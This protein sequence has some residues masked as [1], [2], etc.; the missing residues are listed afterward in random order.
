MI[1]ILGGTTE[2]RA[3]VRVA[4]EANQPYFYSTKGTLQEVVC[5]HGTRLTG[6]MDV[7]AMCQF[8]AANGIRL[9]IDAAHPFASA[10]HQTIAETATRLQLPVIRFERRYPPR[11]PSL[12]WC[13]NYADAIRQME[14]DG[15]EQLLALSGVNTIRPLKP[16]WEKHPC[17]FRIL[18]REESLRIVEREG[19][20][21][22][23]LIFFKEEGTLFNEELGMRN[24][25]LVKSSLL[26]PN[27]SLGFA[28]GEAMALL[29]KES[30]YT[31]G[32][33]EKVEAA[34]AIGIPVY[35]VKRPA[36][37]ETFYFTY[38]EEGLR[39][40]IERL[41]P[42]FF[43]LKSGYTTGC[44]ATAAAK[45]ALL[46]LLTGKRPTEIEIALPSGEWITLPI[47]VSEETR[48]CH[49]STTQVHSSFS[50]SENFGFACVRKDSGDDPDVTTHAL[51]CATVSLHQE[52]HPT[53][54]IRFRAGEGVGTVTLPGLG[55]P[56]GDPA[57]NATP[58]RM[59]QEALIPLLPSPD[60]VATVTISVPSGAE[61]AKRTFN[62]KLGIEGGIS[63]IGTS[64]IVR[65]FSS[66]AFI[67]SI[68]KEA[69]VAKA[70]GCET[71]VINSGAKSE[72]ILRAHFPDLPPQAFV[73]YGNFIGETL[74]I[75]DEIGFKQVVMGIM[76]GKAVKLAEGSLD[77]HSKKVVMNRDFLKALAIEAHCPDELLPA[78]DRL[79]LAREL[80]EILPPA[81]QSPFCQAI[82]DRCAAVCAPLIPHAH[83]TLLLIRED[84]EVVSSSLP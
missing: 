55:L 26:N 75:A 74:R 79:T 72:R 25:E 57:I 14:A 13:E 80:W 62:P 21:K 58:R 45:A 34:K 69:N 59:I 52:E 27:S 46:T 54:R 51:I 84:G 19:F 42:D 63:I 44:C 10:L 82:L 83:L 6:A 24:E 37:P 61:L 68:R 76:L 38:G 70:I 9:L 11:D 77:T 39:K 18:D 43:P 78:I 35:V 15:V 20:P 36:L 66:D 49:V 8:C 56:I 67:A 60:T 29:T 30:G 16:F 40:L 22:E 5:A 17:W 50:D 48:H 3:A 4:D 41:L 28:K 7:E 81:C 23:N 31:G 33:V 53:E 32:F 65:P 12:H 2:G 73:H 1:L 71:L 47:E 64:G